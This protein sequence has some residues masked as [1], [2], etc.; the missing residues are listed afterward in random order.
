MEA[1]AHA[2]SR[3]PTLPPMPRLIGWAVILFCLWFF[4]DFFF[5]GFMTFLLCVVVRSMVSAAHRRLAPGELT[6]RREMWLTLAAY[7][8]LLVGAVLAFQLL[9]PRFISQGRSL[10]TRVMQFDVQGEV[11]QLLA[12]TMGEYLI[13]KNLGGRGSAEYQKAFAAFQAAGKAGAGWYQHFATLQAGLTA[14]FEST[15]EDEN[16][17][18][19]QA[20]LVRNETSDHRFESWFLQNKAPALVERD[21]VALEARWQERQRKQLGEAGF[22]RAQADPAFATKKAQA[23]RQLV[24]EDLKRNP[25]QLAAAQ[26]GWRSTELQQQWRSLRDSTAYQ[27]AFEKFYQAQAAKHPEAIPFTY[28]QYQALAAAYPK[29]EEAFRQAL[30]PALA[31]SGAAPGGE[32]AVAEKDFELSERSRLAKTWWDTDPV[33]LAIRARLAEILPV[34]FGDLESAAAGF[35]RSLLVLPMELI[36]ALFLAMYITFDLRNL[37]R[38]SDALKQTSLGL[39]YRAVL[40]DLK[41]LSDLLGQFFQTRIVVAIFNTVLTWVAMAVL[42]IENELLLAVVVFVTSFIPIFGVFIAGVPIVI[43]AIL[44]PGGSIGL[45]VQ[46][47]VAVTIIHLIE[48]NILSPVLLARAV[49]L[50]PLVI[51]LALIVGNYYFGLWGLILGVPAASFLQRLIAPKKPAEPGTE[52]VAPA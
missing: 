16:L 6:P 15:Y 3:W 12:R 31:N 40:P 37:Q 1:P 46:V 33:A 30:A 34:L 36:T 51:F 41:L 45:A 5:I 19:L 32:L 38:H 24:L 26:S 49:E 23:L 35:F 8:L 2:W 7:L 47:V 50:H 48:A 43:V 27:K 17:R 4:Q 21:R 9:V 13:R 28:A 44:Q 42:G 18:R 20:A 10:L 52:S 29:G 11:D 22:D 39:Y 14:E 25:Q